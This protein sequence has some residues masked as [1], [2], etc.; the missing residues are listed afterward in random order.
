MYV[1][2]VV[3]EKATLNDPCNNQNETKT[4]YE[5]NAQQKQKNQLSEYKV[6]ATLQ[7][8]CVHS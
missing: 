5:L 1:G 3:I 6:S 8:H 7:S 2:F 4:I